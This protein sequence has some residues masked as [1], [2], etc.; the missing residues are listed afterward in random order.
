VVAV[1][2]MRHL[3]VVVVLVDTRQ[4]PCHYLLQL[5]T[6]LLS[7]LVGQQ[8][9]MA[10]I[11]FLALSLLLVVVRAVAAELLVQME[12]LAVVAETEVWLAVLG[13]LDRVTM[14]V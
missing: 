2:V 3:V 1:V 11:Q 7:E 5:I 8:V 14:V 9:L 6:P 13:L 10:L 4:A 12:V